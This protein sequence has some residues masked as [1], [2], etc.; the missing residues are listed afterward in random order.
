MMSWKVFINSKLDGQEKCIA[1]CEFGD[2]ADL[3]F[4]SYKTNAYACRVV[5]SGWM[6]EETTNRHTEDY[7]AVK[8]HVKQMIKG[9]T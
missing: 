4:E 2:D 7:V 5:Y 8:E 1:E 6:G 9:G 3:L